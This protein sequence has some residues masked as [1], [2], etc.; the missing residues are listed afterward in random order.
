MDTLR[1]TLALTASSLLF[2]AG[3]GQA[4]SADTLYVPTQYPTIQDAIDA[5]VKFD[6]IVVSP[7]RYFETIDL[8]GKPITLRSKDPGSD[9]IVAMTIIDGTGRPGSVITTRRGETATTFIAGFTITGG[10]GTPDKIRKAY[11]GGGM[12]IRDASPVVSRCVFEDN[13]LLITPHSS[14]AG[15]GG[16]VACFNGSPTIKHSTFTGNRANF[17]GGVYA[18]HASSVFLAED[19]FVGNR[20]LW[21]GLYAGQGGAVYS[22]GALIVDESVFRQNDADVGGGISLVGVHALSLITR[23]AFVSNYGGDA[24]GAIECAYGASMVLERSDFYWNS[25]QKGGAIRL[26]WTSTVTPLVD[27]C[28]FQSN[29]ADHGGAILLRVA[30]IVIDHSFFVENYG[31]YAGGALRFEAAGGDVCRSTFRRNVTRYEGGAADIRGASTPAFANCSFEGNFSGYA[32]GAVL[33]TEESMTDFMNCMFTENCALYGGGAV[34]SGL[35]ALTTICNATMM[36]NESYVAG[37]ALY[38]EGTTEVM[39]SILWENTKSEIAGSG[40]TRVMHSD[41]QGGYPGPGNIDVDPRC[42]DPLGNDLQLTAESPCIDSAQNSCVPPDRMDLDGDG[43]VKEPTPVD[44]H[45]NPRQ[46]AV[47]PAVPGAHPCVDMGAVEFQPDC[48]ADMNQDRMV[49]FVDLVSLLKAWGSNRAPQDLD[50]NGIV[51]E[52]D[53]TLLMASWGPCP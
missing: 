45:G 47:H 52:G 15:L 40:S 29:E 53:L 25:A 9:Q 26:G 35:N 36:D 13:D 10:S 50:Q 4:A 33:T 17:G 48:K 16:A 7:G 51:G 41:V 22:E 31:L 3:L 32:G 42:V 18:D 49:G 28:R 34:L 24:A 44:F 37:G 6:E 2:V 8:H 14:F 1:R 5:A 46:V 11:V 39:N 21:K 43:D 27:Y 19:S 38:N 30:E 23:S 20:A 12:L